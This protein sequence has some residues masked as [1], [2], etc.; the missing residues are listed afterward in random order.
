MKAKVRLTWMKLHAYFSCFFLPLTLIYI[1]SG[2]LYLCGIKGD[3]KHQASY[4]LTQSSVIENQQQA[5][6]FVKPLLVTKGHSSLPSDYFPDGSGHS[7]YG[8]KHEVVL[9]LDN[10]KKPIE[11]VVKEHDIWL[12]LL[13]IHKGYAGLVFWLLAIG[14]GISLTF[15]L[16]SGVVISLQM[17]QIKKTSLMMLFAGTATFIVAFI[18]G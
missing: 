9:Q 17:P 13:I 11:L 1:L 10:D 12:K 16:L 8:Y 14:L 3:V 18:A 15:S 2:V 4:L 7:W 5:E 6:Q